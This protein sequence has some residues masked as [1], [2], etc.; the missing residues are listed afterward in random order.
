MYACSPQE[1]QGRLLWRQL[2]SRLPRLHP[3][4]GEL[5]RVWRQDFHLLCRDQTKAGL[6]PP[7]RQDPAQVHVLHEA[8]SQAEKQKHHS[9]VRVLPPRSVF[10]VCRSR[11]ILAGRKIYIFLLC[12]RN[13]QRMKDAIRALLV[14]PQNNLKIFKV[15]FFLVNVARQC[16]KIC[17]VHRMVIWF[18]EKERR[19]TYWMFWAAGSAPNIN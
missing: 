6:D 15:L 16:V 4:A 7:R 13:K 5:D 19:L 18:M 14:S 12:C 9:H 3:T 8:V 1:S 17:S 11:L 10:R 2:G